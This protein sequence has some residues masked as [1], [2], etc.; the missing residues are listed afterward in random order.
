MMRLPFNY[1]WTSRTRISSYYAAG[2]VASAAFSAS[3][4]TKEGIRE[5]AMEDYRILLEAHAT[6]GSANLRRAERVRNTGRRD[7]VKSL[8]EDFSEGGTEYVRLASCLRRKLLTFPDAGE[9]SCRNATFR[10]RGCVGHS[11]ARRWGS[12]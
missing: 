9:G 1:I 10:I 6:P 12:G 11:L 7:S 4:A 5:A 3:G 8:V 2:V